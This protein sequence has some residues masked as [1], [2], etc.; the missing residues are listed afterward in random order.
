MTKPDRILVLAAHGSSHPRARKALEAFATLARRKH[1]GLQVLLG[2]TATPRPGGHPAL[3]AGH[4]L[5]DILAG[6]ES[7][8]R[9]DLRVKS[10]HVIAG[11]EFEH[12]RRELSDFALR[13]GARLTLAGPLLADSR[14]VP[15]VAQALAECLDGD[16]AVVLMGHGTTHEAQDLYRLLAARLGE[17]LP[18]ARL[19]VLEAADVGDPLS[20]R[21]IARDLAAA[22]IRRA[23]LLPFLTV[24][25]RHAHND[26][27]G[28]KPE[29][30]KS[31]LAGLGIEGVPDLAGLV[32]REAFTGI[33]LDAIRILAD[34]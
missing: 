27:A 19:G 12:M 17:L 33:W 4:G 15:G 11:D 34:S 14:D 2:Y 13:R 32:E 30:W 22:G 16:E 7:Q 29:S 23:R 25:G 18:M 8:A 9:L 6:L 1:P 28:D 21:A 5:K 3:S 10:L 20:I 31:L 24:A 26:L